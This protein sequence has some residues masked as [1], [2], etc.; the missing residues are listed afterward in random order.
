MCVV[1]S[2]VGKPPPTPYAVG[3]FPIFSIPVVKLASFGI[4]WNGLMGNL[5]PLD[6]NHAIISDINK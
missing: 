5:S 6:Y 3:I 2:E 4:D 1:C